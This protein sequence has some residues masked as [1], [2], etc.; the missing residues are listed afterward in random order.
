MIGNDHQL[1]HGFFTEARAQT[2][3]QFRGG[4]AIAG[5]DRKEIAFLRSK[6]RDFLGDEANR[7]D[8][9]G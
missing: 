3:D 7:F 9:V 4:F 8:P 2:L 5:R 6:R 1:P